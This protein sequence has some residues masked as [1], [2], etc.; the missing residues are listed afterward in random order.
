MFHVE[1]LYICIY[2]D[3]KEKIIRS[4]NL[5]FDAIARNATYV[6]KSLYLLVLKKVGTLER[7]L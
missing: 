5:Y 2:K 6:P 7:V 1:I 4:I 3:I